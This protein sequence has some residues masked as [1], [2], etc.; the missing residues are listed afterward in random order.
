MPFYLRCVVLVFTVTAMVVMGW[1]GSVR[2][3]SR[4]SVIFAGYEEILPGQTWTTEI[5]LHFYCDPHRSS[6]QYDYCTYASANGTFSW[7]GV[8]LLNG[9]INQ[10]N[11]II[12][13]NRI[14]AG[15]LANLWGKPLVQLSGASANFK[16]PKTGATAQ[17]W[18]AKGKFSYFIPLHAVALVNAT[19]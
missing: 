8:T 3:L 13:D 12:I 1:I 19:S 17:G 15:D 11:F 14:T 6:G 4:P 9:V 16:W 5:A 2:F 18:A 7:V 10:V